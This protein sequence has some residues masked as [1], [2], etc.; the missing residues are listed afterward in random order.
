VG[1]AVLDRVAA[2]L[3]AA[4]GREQRI[5]GIAVLLVEPGA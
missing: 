2:Q 5:V 1:K 4:A 3:A